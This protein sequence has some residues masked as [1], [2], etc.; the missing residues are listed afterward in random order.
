MGGDVGVHLWSGEM[1]PRDSPGG[2]KNQFSKHPYLLN[3]SEMP[4]RKASLESYHIVFLVVNPDK[5]KILTA[6]ANMDKF[7]FVQSQ[8]GFALK[9]NLKLLVANLMT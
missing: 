7:K 6:T 4:Y 8:P 3:G 1:L 5:T 2:W 9:D